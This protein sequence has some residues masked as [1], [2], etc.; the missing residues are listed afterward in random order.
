MGSILIDLS[1]GELDVRE[2][3]SSDLEFGADL[4]IFSDENE[5]N[6]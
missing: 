1:P 4:S 6:V 5:R 2:A 3:R